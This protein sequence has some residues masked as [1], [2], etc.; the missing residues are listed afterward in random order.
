MDRSYPGWWTSLWFR[1][2]AIWCL[3]LVAA[4][5]N[6]MLREFVLTPLLGPGVAELLSALLLAGLILLAAWW[7]V[8]LTGPGRPMGQWFLVGLLW[9]G[10]TLAL[11]IGFFHYGMGV[12]WERLLADWDIRRGGYFGLIVL[13]TRGAPMMV[14]LAH[15]GRHYGRPHP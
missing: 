7:L 4:A 13:V 5:F 2:F 3:L 6:G 15:W 9:A 11:E 12:P 10:L 8:R 14:G 1:A